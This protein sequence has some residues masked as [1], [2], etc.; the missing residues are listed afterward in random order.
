M[1]G[2]P[3]RRSSHEW[4]E[5]YHNS[6]R[7]NNPI[8]Q[9]SSDVGCASYGIYNKKD[10]KK[11]KII[12]HPI[13]LLLK[14]PNPNKTIT[15]YNLFYLIQVY[16]LLPNGES[17]V[18]KE[19][20][21]LG[22]V[23][24]LWI[25]PPSWVNE[26]P[27]VINPYYSIYPQGNMQAGLIKVLPEDMI[28]FKDPDITQ[29]Y[30]RGIGRANAL[31]DD[32]EVDEQ[33]V[34]YSKRFFYNGAIPSAVGI[35][36]GADPETI[37]RTEE[38]W[39]QKY[40]GTSN[41]H[42]M[43]FLNWDAK[44]QL[45]K[46]TNKD[47]EFIESR[48]YIRD[49]SNQFFNIPPELMGILESSNRSTIDASYFLYSKNVLRK[50][51]KFIADVLNIQLVPEFDKNVYLE[52]DEVV[53]EDKEYE[54]KKASEGLKNGG[55]LVDE[56]RR[57]N[58]WSELPNGKG[59]ILY[60]PLNMIPVPIGDNAFTVNLE[61][62]QTELPPTESPQKPKKKELT[63]EHKERMWHVFDKAAI[64]YERSFESAAKRFFQGQQERVNKSIE[65]SSKAY[66]EPFD[67]DEEDLLL[68]GALQAFWIASMQE[69]FT[70]ANE[71]YGFGLSWDVFNPRFKEFIDK[72]GLDQAKEI[73]ETT[74]DKLRK[75]L[76]EGIE[77]GES[78]VKLRD[79]VSEIFT[80]AKTNRA[81]KIAITETHNTVGAGTFETYKGAKIKQKEWLSTSDGR[82]RDT[83]AAINHQ[84]VDTDKPFSNGLM[85]PG[86][87]SGPPEEICNC[88]C[89]L[90]PIIPE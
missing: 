34:K 37:N 86:D 40:G 17:F 26:I 39:N 11:I 23:T 3:P 19:R 87:A 67:W 54:L 27:S 47:L 9:I 46:E 58:G 69:G 20:N 31:G 16:L 42:K 65:K 50:R 18:I 72:Y 13:D 45:L 6:P 2:E 43:A 84:I 8:N 29:P 64:K 77:A 56:W 4:L 73:N 59:Q 21:G 71:T 53:P 38:L 89:V 25:C 83:H 24:E 1:Y 52:Y 7:L 66:D 76:S 36:P 15:A 41:S 33:M 5:M 74:K 14:N 10:T 80:E 88:R 51:L 85:F 79:R 82:T 63:P 28:H 61:P 62:Q 35:M 22:K 12:D 75:T 81:K 60:V 44:V 90:L 57:A 78:I 49:E 70:V 30:L 55:L 48:R 32:I 68:F